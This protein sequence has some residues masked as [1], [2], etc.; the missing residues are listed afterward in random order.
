[1]KEQDKN[2][3][4]LKKCE[5]CNKEFTS[6]LSDNR[7]YCDRKCFERRRKPSICKGCGIEFYIAGEPNQKYH[8]QEC[9]SINGN[10]GTFKLEHS[11]NEGKTHSLKTKEQMSLKQRINR[12]NLILGTIQFPNF[13]RNACL[14]INEYGISNGYNFQHA[15]NGGEFHIKELGYWVDGYDKKQN[16]VIEYYEKHHFTPKW[17]IKDKIRQNNIIKVLKCKF[18]ILHYNNQIEIYED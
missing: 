8:S 14:L 6:Y 12:S 13:N 3:K 4:N 1:M 17:L 15:L 5:S 10:I 16:V 9:Y 2:T 7:K 18:I 11:I